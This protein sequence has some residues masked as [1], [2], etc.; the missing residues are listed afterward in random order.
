MNLK[1]VNAQCTPQIIIQYHVV[2]SRTCTL[3]IKTH[4]Q[5]HHCHWHPHHRHTSGACHCAWF[6]S[7]DPN[8]CFQVVCTMMH[9]VRCRKPQPTERQP[10]RRPMHVTGASG[11]V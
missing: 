1:S 11:P 7:T 2:M 9:S 5:L 3:S 4:S 10:Q 8:M 6:S